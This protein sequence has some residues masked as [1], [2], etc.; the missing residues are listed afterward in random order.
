MALNTSQLLGGGNY[1]SIAGGSLD[2]SPIYLKKKLLYYLQKNLVFDKFADKEDLPEGNGK[3][4]RFTRY[5]RIGLPFDP[6]TEGVT[7]TDLR[8]LAPEVVEGFVDQW[9]DVGVV[10]DVAEMTIMHKPLQ[11]L[12]ERMGT[13]GGEL[14]DREHQ[15]VLNANGTVVFP[16]PAYTG[17]AQL[18]VND[19]LDPDVIG[20][21]V[22]QMRD[23]GVPDIDGYYY[24]IYDW[25]TDQD[26]FREPVFQTMSTYQAKEQLQKGMISRTWLGLK[27]FPTNH[28]PYIRRYEDVF[29]PI[30]S[31]TLADA[32]GA[33]STNRDIKVTALTMFGFE[34]LISDVMTPAAWAA[35]DSIQVNL[36]NIAGWT[37]FNIYAGPVAGT[38][39]K[40][41]TVALSPGV[42]VITDSGSTT[43]ATSLVPQSNAL[44]YSTTGVVA[45]TSIPTGVKIHRTYIFGKETY[46]NV[47][48]DPMDVNITPRVPS[49]SDPAMQRRKVSYKLMNKSV[50]KNSQHLRVIEH[51]S[52]FD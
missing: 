50:L 43:T 20:R 9:I 1:T 49:D 48:L 10:T 38:L 46:G 45:P 17:R 41:N 23:T 19:V 3:A 42:Y 11:I 22:S 31:T 35:G 52:A 40:I 2:M 28:I 32:A 25:F 47:E 51:E 7:P 37:K 18:T 13:S 29:S 6:A 14:V 30:T 39:R 5:P 8:E 21:V 27:W 24:A 4:F 26:L 12:L 33:T 15:R 34:T 44:L 36:P 16:N